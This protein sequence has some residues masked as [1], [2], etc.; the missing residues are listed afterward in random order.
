MFRAYNLQDD[1][2]WKKFVDDMSKL[3]DD[4]CQ[5]CLKYSKELS[6]LK[7]RYHDKK[8]STV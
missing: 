7:V 8:S 6:S 4:S 3:Q 2:T 5:Q 1:A